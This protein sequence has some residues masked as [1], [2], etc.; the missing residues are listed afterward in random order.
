MITSIRKSN[1]GVNAYD[2]DIVAVQG[3]LSIS[4]AEMNELNNA[5][6]PISTQVISDDLLSPGHSGSQP[7]VSP[8]RTRGID[9][10]DAYVMQINSRK[11]VGDAVRNINK[12]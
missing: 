7:E 1:H 12:S 6:M 11:R 8:L 10:S 3:G 5:H 9:F 4:P 2:G